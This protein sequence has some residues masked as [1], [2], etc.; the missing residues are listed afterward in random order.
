ML[1]AEEREALERELADALAARQAAQDAARQQRQQD[2]VQAL[3]A[4]L[5][6]ALAREQVQ[7]QAALAREAVRLAVVMAER[8]LRRELASD[9]GA[10]V[11]AVEMLLRKVSAAASLRVTVNPEDAS[12]LRAQPEQLARLRVVEV[13]EDRRVERGGCLVE[14][15]R[16]Q[17]D[18]TVSGQLETLAAA[19]NACLEEASESDRGA[20]AAAGGEEAADVDGAPLG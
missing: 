10:V 17:W 4:G 12:Y 15:D 19:I 9:T 20:A 7:T 5:G 2:E 14:A 1:T 8:I 16:R 18:A 11:R 3:L 6:D 13:R